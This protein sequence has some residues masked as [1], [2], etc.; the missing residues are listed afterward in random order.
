[1]HI[2]RLIL[3]FLSF[4]TSIFFHW[5][6][7]FFRVIPG[8]KHPIVLMSSFEAVIRKK[9]VDVVDELKPISQTIKSLVSLVELLH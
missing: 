2:T 6:R 5:T 8:Y 9:L 7:F 3:T 1:M 4:C